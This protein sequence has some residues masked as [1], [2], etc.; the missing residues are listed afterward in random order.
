MQLPPPPPQQNTTE[1]Q[2][3]ETLA[4]ACLVAKNCPLT[5]R[6]NIT[7]LQSE[8]RLA[9]ACLLAN[10]QLP[11]PEKI[12][13]SCSHVEDMKLQSGGNNC[14]CMLGMDMQLPLL[15]N[16]LELQSGATLAVVRLVA[17]MQ[18]PPLPNKKHHIVADVGNICSCMPSNRHATGPSQQNNIELQSH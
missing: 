5:P 12:P 16:N 14:T 11:L 18:L 6:K 7:W 9:V 1:L 17:D 2:S 4:V 15:E 13:Q 10:M 3:G 8:A